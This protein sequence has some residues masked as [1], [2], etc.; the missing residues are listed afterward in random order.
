MNFC[1]LLPIF[2]IVAY[3][4]LKAQTV[5]V[6]TS[7]VLPEY[8]TSLSYQTVWKN[9]GNA[10]GLTKDSLIV[11]GKTNLRYQNINGSYKL[12]QQAKNNQQLTFETERYLQ[13]GKSLFYGRFSYSQ[14]WEKEVRLSDVLDPYRGTPYLWADSIGGDWKKQLYALTLKVSTPALLNEKL[15]LGLSADLNVATGAR[16]N[17]PRPLAT[18]NDIKISP[19]LVWNINS[20]HALGLNGI[21]QRYREDVSM[22]TKN[23]TINHRIYR[24]LGLGQM[25]LPTTFTS[26]ASR[27]YEGQWLGASIQYHLKTKNIEWLNNFGY[28]SGD[29]EVAEGS[30]IP[31]KSGTWKQASYSFSSQ[32]NLKN[33]QYHHYFFLDLKRLQDTG[34]EF[35]EIYDA[36]TKNWQTILE[37]DFYI[38]NTDQAQLSYTL[39]KK[40]SALDFSWLAEGGVN[41][42]AIDKNY[43]IPVSIQNVSNAEI[44]ARGL[45]N[46]SIGTT[47]LHIGI[48][49]GYSK[50]LSQSLHFVP[51]TG[52]RTL[53]T[54]EVLYPD[55]G[56]LST[57]Y[58]SANIQFQYNFKLKN[59][60]G[61]RFFANTNYTNLHSLTVPIY[62][63]AQGNRNFFS[64]GLG[65][66]Y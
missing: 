33:K 15:H 53:A 27:F 44:W 35:H 58:L 52:D 38:A 5:P 51:I 18:N 2:L 40:K 50:N 49:F 63:S 9:S 1:R 24:L 17:D 11:F 28:K 37:A 34:V 4:S 56:Y 57:D 32:V 30:S 48:R 29:E 12:A 46:L 66:F 21:Y 3:P 6:D 20:H 42:L 47:S 19:A 8:T 13:L 31:R 64:L 16:Q 43:V 41:Y 36:T 45:K 25:E 55:H 7:A 65:A 14:Q 26:S 62:G 54:R 61:T 23:T 60:T 39:I 22:E 59:V 10:A